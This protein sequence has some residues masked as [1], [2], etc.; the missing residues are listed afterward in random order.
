MTLSPVIRRAI[1]MLWA[2]ACLSA[3][4]GSGEAADAP[5]SSFAGKQMTLA[6]PAQPGSGYDSYARS[7]VR[8]LPKHLPG[9]PV[10]VVQ[11]M[12]GAGGMRLA[13]YL[14]NVAPKDGLALG[15]LENG[16]PFEP[17]YENHQVQFDPAKFN[18]L[19]SPSRETSLFLLW[20]SV[21]VSTIAE[22]R[23]R[24]L[25]LAAAGSGSGGAFYARLLGSIFGLNVHLVEGYAGF[26]EALLAM[27]RGENDGYPSGFWSTLKSIHQNWID[28]GQIKFLLRW[29]SDPNPALSTVP[30]AR[31]LV[32]KVEDRQVLQVATAPFSLG[33]PIAAPPGVPADRLRQLRDAMQATFA[34]PAFREDCARQHLD[35]EAPVT[36]EQLAEIIRAAYVVPDAVHRRLIAIHE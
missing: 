2:A 33:R 32:D 8:I 4:P 14:Y 9:S 11:N 22:A 18:W 20:H 34:D 21:P 31:D 36:G 10:I 28:S 26:P 13:N 6:V 5:A 12:P 16:T 19:G 24:E 29:N 30:T 35:C 17:F 3:L 25:V 1:G 27:E 15:M 23:G 7:I